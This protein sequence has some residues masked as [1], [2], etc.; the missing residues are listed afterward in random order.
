ML[1]YNKLLAR[2]QMC[3][4]LTLAW[5][6]TRSLLAVPADRDESG[7]GAARNDVGGNTD[8]FD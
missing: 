8:P 1:K 5:K 2:K 4:V 7:I 6:G 3:Y